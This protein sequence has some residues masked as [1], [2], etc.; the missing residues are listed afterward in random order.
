MS[1]EVRFGD[2]ST[3][4]FQVLRL[5]I[6]GAVMGLAAYL[7]TLMPWEVGPVQETLGMA[8]G[9]M[10]LGLAATP[11]ARKGVLVNGLL[12]FGIALLGVLGY[13]A[14]TSTPPIYRWFGIFIYGASVG[15]I[16]GRDLRDRR[17]YLLPA[18]TGLSVMVAVFVVTTF[19]RQVDFTAY[20]PA[21]V[22]G[23]AY[24]GL[25]GFLA[26]VALVVRQL[27]IARDPVG[28]AFA[29]VRPSLSGEM[30]ELCQRAVELYRRVQDVLKD[31][32]ESGSS[33]P[34]LS[35]AVQDMVLRIFGL[36]RKWHEVEREA[37]RTSV[38]DLQKRAAE[39]DTKL[40][41]TRDPVARR[42]YRMAR[43]AL[44]SQLRYLE[45]IS[46]NRERVTAQVYNY[47]AA[48]E[49]LHLAVL[50]HR[51]AD[52]AKLADEIMP[53]FD[54]IDDVGQEMDLESDAMSEAEEAAEAAEAAGAAEVA[55]AVEAARAEPEET[56]DPGPVQDMVLR[57]VS[58]E[59]GLGE[60][61]EARLA[62]RMF[63]TDSGGEAA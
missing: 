9:A 13:L 36:A 7:V 21:L 37:A 24:G 33:D 38:D 61:P 28:Q 29:E 12:A 40:A 60:D 59:P 14:L 23:P 10:I 27:W 2:H 57:E 17:R 25:F 50:N 19:A 3:F 45:D 48:L 5:S 20:V 53:I 16:A 58:T 4:H 35:R 47:V 46:R 49:R 30:L 34:E 32:R 31:R 41:Q 1:N 11:P 44:G 62:A 26:G 22:A 51:G 63:D 55:E 8:L 42:Q 15:V 54:E 39:V 6:A 18:A 52:A 56:E 43:E